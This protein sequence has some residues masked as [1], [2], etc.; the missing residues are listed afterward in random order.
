[1]ITVRLD[2]AK[3]NRDQFDCGVVVL[4]NYLKTMAS[5]QAQKDNTRTFVLE[6]ETYASVIIGFYT[7]TMISV[8]LKNL[9][10]KLQEKHHTA[11]TAGLIARLAVDK[12]YTGKGFGE[13]LLIDALKRLL[14][15]SELV[16]FPLV[17]VDAK[18]GAIGFYEKF[19]FTSFIDSLNKLYLTINDIRVSIE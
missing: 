13:L 18:D 8:D 4:N 3:H 16:A 15:A 1:M 10:E 19:G 12:R 7:L 2:K 5:Q 14:E 6:D 17:V 9:P 11:N